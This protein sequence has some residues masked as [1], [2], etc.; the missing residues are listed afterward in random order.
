VSLSPSLPKI[1]AHLVRI[2]AFTEIEKRGRWVPLGAVQQEA[3]P[4]LRDAWMTRAYHVSWHAD[5]QTNVIATPA[6]LCVV[7]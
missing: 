6:L 7:C 2:R 5:P 1:L 4:L 3:G